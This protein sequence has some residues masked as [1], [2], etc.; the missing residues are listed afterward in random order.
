MPDEAEQIADRAPEGRAKM[1]RGQ[2]DMEE[3][4]SSTKVD[5]AVVERDQEIQNLADQAVKVLV[6]VRCQSRQ[7]LS[8]VLH[9]FWRLVLPYY[10]SPAAPT[11]RER[12][13]YSE[14][15]EACFLEGG[16]R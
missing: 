1:T 2:G 4:Q 5:A 7:L 12:E 10:Q 3:Y 9:R 14:Q 11:V 15:M 8:R 6:E 16:Y 13:V